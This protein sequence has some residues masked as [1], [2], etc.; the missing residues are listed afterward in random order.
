MLEPWHTQHSYYCDTCLFWDVLGDGVVS[1]VTVGCDGPIMRLV[2]KDSPFLFFFFGW[3][4][5]ED[6]DEH[7]FHIAS[8]RE[9]WGPLHN[10]SSTYFLPSKSSIH[11]CRLPTR[12]PTP[13]VEDTSAKPP[14]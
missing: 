1:S 5:R 14:A 6:W 7:N 10:L 12:L 4:D 11:C 3:T 9:T 2:E 13:P 8:H